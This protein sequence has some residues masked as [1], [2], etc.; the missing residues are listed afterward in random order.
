MAGGCHL[1][2]W[3]CCRRS[4]LYHE[5]K[6]SQPLKAVQ[7]CSWIG[8]R[9]ATATSWTLFM[10]GNSCMHALLTSVLWFSVTVCIQVSC[11]A[12]HLLKNPLTTTL[13]TVFVAQQ[14]W[15]NVQTDCLGSLTQHVGVGKK[16]KHMV[17]RSWNVTVRPSTHRNCRHICHIMTAKYTLSCFSGMVM[18]HWICKQG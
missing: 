6:L 10:D 5:A 9:L 15:G 17:S 8:L 1:Y 4:R 11:L 18:K 3:I 12:C 16:A 7:P 14:C 2:N 13:M